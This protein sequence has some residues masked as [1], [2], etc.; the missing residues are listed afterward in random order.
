MVRKC[1]IKVG[2]NLLEYGDIRWVYRTGF[3]RYGKKK[4]AKK[5]SYFWA[6]ILCF[7]IKHQRPFKDDFIEIVETRKIL[8]K[9][10]EIRRASSEPSNN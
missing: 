10:T 4:F 6:R 7:F 5:Y 2:I 1:M 9:E 3:M 8:G